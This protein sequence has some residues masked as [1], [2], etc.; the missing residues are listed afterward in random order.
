MSV[1]SFILE[2][3]ELAFGISSA[4]TIDKSENVSILGEVYS[5]F[6]IGVGSVR[7][8]GKDHWK[9]LLHLTRLVQCG[10][11]LDTVTQWYSDIPYKLSLNLFSNSRFCPG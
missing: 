6:M 10:G 9:S 8:E 1:S 2:R 4:P 7:S 5:T 11:E 3:L